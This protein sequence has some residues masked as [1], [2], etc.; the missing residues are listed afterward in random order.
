MVGLLTIVI[1]SE[2]EAIRR[3]LLYLSQYLI[4]HVFANCTSGHYLYLEASYFRPG[5]RMVLTTPEL[6]TSGPD[7]KFEFWY[8]MKGQ[9]IG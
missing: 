5:D 6:L 1:L 4:F 2:W 9:S 7:C 8:H 3:P